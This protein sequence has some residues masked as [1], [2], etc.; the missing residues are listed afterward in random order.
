MSLAQVSVQGGETARVTVSL[1]N[2]VAFDF[3]QSHSE[4]LL[5]A[6]EFDFPREERPL[7]VLPLPAGPPHRLGDVAASDACWG[8]DGRSL[9]FTNGRDVFVAEAN[10][11]RVRK[12]ATADGFVFAFW[13]RFS[14]DGKR[15][16]FSVFKPG[17]TDAAGDDIEIM[18]MNVDGSGLQRLPIQGACCGNWSPDGKYYFYKNGRD[19]WALPERQTFLGKTEVG[20][21]V[22]LTAGPL[23]FGGPTPSTDGKHLFVIGKHLRVE[24]VH[25]DPRSRQFTPFLGGISAGE[26]EVSRDGQWVTYTTFPDGNLWRSKLDG[27]ERLQLT[28]A[29]MNAHEPRWSPD[30]KQILFAD[31]PHK[32]FVVSADGGA[33]RQLMS[34]DRPDLIGAGAWLPDGGSIIFGRKGCTTDKSCFAIYH[35]DLK[36][37]QV[38]KIPGSEGLA[39]ARLS[40][41]GH[42]LVAL[43]LSRDKRVMLYDL[44]T[45]RWSQLAQAF[46]SIAWSR[47]D[48]SV[49][50]RTQHEAKPAEL[51]RISVPDGRV[52]RVIDLKGVTLGGFWPDWVSLLPDDS[53]LFMWE[54]STEEIYRLDLQYR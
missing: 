17:A 7:W 13:I 30:G 16:R 25:Y 22:Q 36:T 49:Y 1:R 21:P 45:N 51:I 2:P 19:I 14:P 43:P 38:S 44:R 29:P 41:H 4:L 52:Q 11:S 42:Y 40:H 5:G 24:L 15:L 12:L 26:L 37:E 35:L 32:L 31:L 50:L 27:S 18:E 8:P 53:P 34:A 48:R 6:G 20:A 28:F 54:R 3:S 10:G 33:P 23:E 39:A 9:A 46:G 47:D